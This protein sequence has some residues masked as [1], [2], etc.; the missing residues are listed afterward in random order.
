V[1]LYFSKLIWRSLDLIYPPTCAG[2]GKLG[3]RWCS[4]CQEKV[5]EIKP[6][7]CMKCGEPINHEGLCE[8]CGKSAPTYNELRS[9]ALFLE[10][11]RSAI[12]RLKYKRDL[13]LG[14]LFS[15]YLYNLFQEINWQIDK[16]VP[17]PLSQQRYAERRINQSALLIRPLAL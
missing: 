16:I 10:P 8:R 1:K 2:C 4:D 15:N 6:P 7:I 9:Y 17:V 12:H 13:A 5:K 3:E 14:D 11:L